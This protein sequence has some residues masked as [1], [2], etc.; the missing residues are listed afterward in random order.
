MPPSERSAVKPTLA[1]ALTLTVALVALV[2]TSPA[3]ADVIINDSGKSI[4]IDCAKD[5][6]IAINGSSHHLT[7]TGACTKI[8]VNGSSIEMTIESVTKLAVNGSSNAIGV[9]AADK[10]MVTGSRNNVTYR[11]GA[12]VRKPKVAVLGSGN[13]VKKVK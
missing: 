5:P 7:I 2:A 13:K 6:E 12:S 11:R 10:I 1:V 3:R 8:A 9:D 4:A